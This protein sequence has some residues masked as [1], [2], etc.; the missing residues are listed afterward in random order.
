MV[1]D[2]KPYYSSHDGYHYENGYRY[3]NGDRIDRDGHRDANWCANHLDDEH[4][5]P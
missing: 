3:E 1:K 4:C 5:R 2:P